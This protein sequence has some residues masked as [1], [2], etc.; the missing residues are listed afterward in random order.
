MSGDH[1][2]LCGVSLNLSQIYFILDIHGRMPNIF[3]L[4]Q[5]MSELYLDH[6]LCSPMLLN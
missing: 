2:S 1:Y 5:D 4:S 6:L 3:C